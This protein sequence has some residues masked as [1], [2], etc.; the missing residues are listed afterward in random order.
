LVTK[1]IEELEKE[2][3]VQMSRMM[4]LYEEKRTKNL[5]WSS[6]ARDSVVF[7]SSVK[8][9]HKVK[10]LGR[11]IACLDS[12]DELTMRD[13]RKI[14]QKEVVCLRRSGFQFLLRTYNPTG[15]YM[16]TISTQTSRI[17]GMS[18]VSYPTTQVILI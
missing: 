5:E 3:E 10:E 12:T 1:T 18:D 4:V 15:T 6:R 13:I 17:G 2:R 7:R 11:D 16:K 9:D 8:L 14:I